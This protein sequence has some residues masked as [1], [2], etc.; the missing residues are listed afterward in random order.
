MEEKKAYDAEIVYNES[1]R[2]S[3]DHNTYA[4]VFVKDGK[5]VLKDVLIDNI[6]IKELVV[7]KEVNYK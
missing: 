4:L 1:L 3:I 6:S 7:E 5:A 2:D